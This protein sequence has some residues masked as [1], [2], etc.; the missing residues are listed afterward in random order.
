MAKCK[1]CGQGGFLPSVN[2]M[3]LCDPCAQV[4][5]PTIQSY[6]ETIRTC[7]AEVN[8][9]SLS[10]ADKLSRLDLIEQCVNGIC[11]YEKMGIPIGKNNDYAAAS[12][13]IA[14]ARV[15]FVGGEADRLIEKAKLQSD[16]AATVA[17]RVA[18]FKSLLAQLFDLQHLIQD[19]GCITQRIQRVQFDI[20]RIRIDGFM[21]SARKSE[22][23]GE[24]RQAIGQYQEALFHVKNDAVDDFFQS[25]VIHELEHKISEISAKLKSGE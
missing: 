23:K 17:T 10:L 25:G 14:T 19:P 24:F 7:E 5:L 6:L 12:Q 22:F 21:D 9:P 11:E 2:P 18:P 13:L 20:N 15:E 8:S 4:V 3:G 1:Y 16:A